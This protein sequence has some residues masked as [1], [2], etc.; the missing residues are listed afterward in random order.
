MAIPCAIFVGSVQMINFLILSNTHLPSSTAATI[1][2]KLSSVK[3]ISADSFATSVPVIPIAT[4][5]FACFNAGASFTPS[6]VIATILFCT[7]NALTSL[8]FCSGVTL[9]NT[10][11]FTDISFNFSSSYCSSWLPVIAV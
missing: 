10:E 4:P 8:N 7:C 9:A 5:I 1:E 3:T 11:Y 2:A 6:P